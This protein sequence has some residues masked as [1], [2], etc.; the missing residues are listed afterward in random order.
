MSWLIFI[1]AFF[2]TIMVVVGIHESSHFLAAKLMGVKVLR[3]SIGFGKSLISFHDKSGTEYVFALIPL[4][5]YVKMLGETDDASKEE[6]KQSYASQPFYKKACIILAGPL[7]NFVCAWILYSLV[8]S[9]GF[10]ALKPILGPITPTSIAAKAGLTSHDEI[11]QVDDT[12][13]LSWTKVVFQFVLHAGDT[14]PLLVRT[15]KICGLDHT[16][17]NCQSTTATHQMDLSTWSLNGLKPDP[18]GSLGIAPYLPPNIT[19]RDVMLQKIQYSPIDAMYHAYLQCKEL[20]Y[21]NL[22][23]IKKM[24]FGQLSLD[25]LGGPIAIFDTAGQA[26]NQ[27]MVVFLVFLAFMNLSIG[28]INLFPIPGLDGGQLLLQMIEWILRKPISPIAVEIIVRIG[29]AVLLLLFFR[30]LYNDILRL[31]Q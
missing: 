28:L 30:V 22:I 17:M 18:L 21:F 19:I 15:K 25:G 27:G 6:Q 7:S 24:L 23:V 3:F 13:T 5:G 9:I 10:S 4:G 31:M 14:K 20:T 8:Y 16:A 1:L 2:I 29:F 12:E 26:L 11:I